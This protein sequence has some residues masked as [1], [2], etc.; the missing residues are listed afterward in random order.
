MIGTAIPRGLA[1]VVLV[2]AL[3]PAVASASNMTHPRTPV[4]WEGTPCLTLHDR[5]EDPIFHLEY[6]IPFE[7]L[8]VTPDEV[9]G[10]R[11]HQFFAYCRPHHPQDFLPTW[12]TQADVDAAVAAELVG[13]G[14]VETTDILEFSEHWA[15]C[16]FR[17]NG[18]DERRPISNAMAAAGVD[19]DTSAVPAGVYTLNGYTYEPVFNIWT[20]RPGVMKIHDG[21]PHAI[22]PAAAI[23]TGELTPYRDDEVM[24]EGCAHALPG[25][26]F[27]AYW[28]V[29][30]MPNVEPDWI[31][32]VVDQE[33]PGEDFA[34]GFTPP[35]PLWGESGLIRVDVSDPEGRTYTAYQADNM[36]VIN[37]DNPDSC[38]QGGSFIGSPCGGTTGGD[39]STGGSE[40]DTAVGTADSG[41]GESG[42]VTDGEATGN[43]GQTGD[44]GGAPKGCAC[45][46]S[47]GVGG[48][49]LVGLVVPLVRRRRRARPARGS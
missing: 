30:P 2:G 23:S 10:S 3:V 42:D 1:P 26:T 44:D 5:S 37:S 25:S 15:D 41:D 40:G 43:S 36:L 46:A 13:E 29:T 21:D 18:D 8:D 47:G 39:D 49:W 11:R 4:T 19:W 38:D 9:P 6:G 27:T 31:E 22:G 45:A 16:W 20:L 7:D 28:A 35:E 12:I 48:T 32:Y 24:I 33:L 14:V 34:F 17:I